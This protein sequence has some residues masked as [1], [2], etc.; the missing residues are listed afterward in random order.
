MSV[1]LEKIDCNEALPEA[2]SPTN[3]SASI[4]PTEVLGDIEELEN[5]DVLQ[6]KM[7]PPVPSTAPSV[8]S[9]AP[10]VPSA[11]P[12]VPS[13]VPA[14]KK[15]GRPKALAQVEKK[16][17][18][19]KARVPK[20]PKAPQPESSSSE[21]VDETLRSVYRHAAKPDMET[22]ILQFLV[23]RRQSQ[24]SR[25]RELWSNLAQM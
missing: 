9:A 17:K 23:N 25:R 15:R 12:A 5:A 2:P 21:D 4:S 14:P 8:P 16:P 3:V 6:D 10:A 19:P 11:V 20:P 13:A 1:V 24:S 22:A 18:E 7:E